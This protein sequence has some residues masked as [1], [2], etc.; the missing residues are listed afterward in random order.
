MLQTAFHTLSLNSQYSSQNYNKP[1]PKSGFKS[2][3]GYGWNRY[4]FSFPFWLAAYKSNGT[5][6]NQSWKVISNNERSLDWPPLKTAFKCKVSHLSSG[7]QQQKKKQKSSQQ[8]HNV[9]LGLQSQITCCSQQPLFCSIKLHKSLPWLFCHG[10]NKQGTWAALREAA[11]DVR[12]E[13]CHT[14]QTRGPGERQADV[15]KQEATVHTRMQNQWG[16][17]RECGA[18]TNAVAATSKNIS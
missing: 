14:N 5:E 2:A 11:A 16:K 13:W 1:R 4:F 18:A 7:E 17:K 8:I 9:R 10:Q 3:C 12:M 6:E 15:S